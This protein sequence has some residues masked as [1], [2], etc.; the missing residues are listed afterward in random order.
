M[1]ENKE[2]CL[3]IDGNNLIYRCYY[4]SQKLTIEKE[5]GTVFIFLRIIIS[6]LKEN[7]YQKLFIAFDSDKKN[8]RHTLFPNYK[9]NRSATPPELIQKIIIIQEL[10]EKTGIAFAK[11][12][13][14][15]ADDLI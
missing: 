5:I 12:N 10:L 6:L 7:N 3:I 15:E 2:K 9:I 13:S 1:V 8:F 4:V 11:L 14:F